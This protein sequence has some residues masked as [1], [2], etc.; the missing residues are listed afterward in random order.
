VSLDVQRQAI[1]A[2]AQVKAMTLE[3]E[4]RHDEAEAWRAIEVLEDAGK[5]GRTMKYRPGLEQLR[6]LV[7]RREVGTVV[8][9]SLTRLGRSMLDLLTLMNDFQSAGCDVVSLKESLDS[10][11]AAGRMVI[12][13][14]SSLAEFESATIA[15]RT[16]ASFA[17]LRSRGERAA[18]QVFG[19]RFYSVPGEKKPKVEP[20]PEEMA[21]IR[22]A[23]GMLRRGQSY[24]AVARYLS[25]TGLK[26]RN[27][28][29]WHHSN[30]KKMLQSRTL[31]A[32]VGGSR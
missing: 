7:G 32:Y 4:Q 18:S 3:A 10:S 6:K 15:E 11:S 27:G 29:Q 30:A 9:W 1:L 8:V 19:F 23:Q 20:V 14:L 21:A 31:A 2:T 22:R 12:G 26:P 24:R 28:G 25:D 5:T 13:I 17:H 16:A